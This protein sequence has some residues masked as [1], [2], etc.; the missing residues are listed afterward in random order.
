[1]APPPLSAR[2][3]MPSI[4]QGRSTRGRGLVRLMLLRF[5]VRFRVWGLGVRV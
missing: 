3:I 5:R 4:D 1:M 2:A